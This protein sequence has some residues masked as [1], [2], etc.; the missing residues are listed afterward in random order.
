VSAVETLITHL[1]DDGIFL[2]VENDELRFRAP[3][4]RFSDTLKKDVSASK[5]EVIKWL[6]SNGHTARPDTS[7]P[8]RRTGRHEAPLTYAQQQLWLADRLSGAGATYNMPAHIVLKGKLKTERLHSAMNELVKRHE[9]LRTSF[10]SQFDE[11]RQIINPPSQL[12]YEI[13]DVEN[14]TS[15]DQYTR[16]E[17][18]MDRLAYSAFDLS[19]D[20]LLRYG[21]IRFNATHHNVILCLHHIVSD[22]WSMAVLLE[23]LIYFYNAYQDQDRPVLT[24][25]YADFAAWQKQSVNQAK[26]EEQIGFWKEALSGVPETSEFPTEFERPSERAF[27]GDEHA[28]DFGPEL[29]QAI[30]NLAKTEGTT[31]FSVLLAALYISLWRHSGQADLVIGTPVAGRVLQQTEPM[32]GLFATVLPLRAVVDG[33]DDFRTFLSTVT[34]VTQAAQANQAVP[35]ERI[36]ELSG[37]GRD[38]SRQPLFQ[39]AL[40]LENIPRP[41]MELDG[42]TVDLVRLESR[43]SRFDITIFAQDIADNIEGYVE[44]DPALYTKPRIESLLESIKAVLQKAVRQCD[45]PLSHLPVMTKPTL[46]QLISTSTGPDILRP[47]LCLHHYIE[48]QVLRTPDT[49]ALTFENRHLTYG[50][51]NEQ[52]NQLAIWLID[53]G[54]RPGDLVG[55]CLER[56]FDL[57]IALLAVMKSGRAYVP[58]DPTLPRDRLDFMVGDASPKVILCD[59]QCLQIFANMSTPAIDLQNLMIECQDSHAGNPSVSL[60][61]DDLIHVIYTSGSTGVP[62]G[63]TSCHAGALNRLLWG[64]EKYPLTDRDVLLQKTPYSFDVSVW[65][66]FWP[67]MQGARLV[68]AKPGGHKDP[69]YLAE[70]VDE[71]GITKIHFV[72]SMLDLFLD[73]KP[74]GSCTRLEHVICSGEALTPRLRQKFFQHFE[75]LLTNLYGPTEASIEVTYQDCYAEDEGAVPIGRPISNVDIFILDENRLPVPMGVVGELHIGGVALAQG[76][77]NRPDLTQDR[78]ITLPDGPLKGRRL[79]KTGD[80]ARYTSSGLIEYLGRT[81]HQIKLRGVRIELGE[82]ESHLDR[83]DKIAQSVVVA[84][85]DIPGNVYLASYILPVEPLTDQ[86]GFIESLKSSLSQSLPAYML[87]AAYVIMSE[88]PLTHNGKVDRKALPQPN[89]QT[90]VQQDKRLPVTQFEKSMA[91]LWSELLGIEV[92]GLEDDFFALGGNSLMVVRL[93]SRLKIDHD[94]DMSIVQFFKDPTIGAL[95]NFHQQGGLQKDNIVCLRNAKASNLAPPL[96]FIHPVGGHVM[97]YREVIDKLEYAGPIFGINHPDLSSQTSP[98]FRTVEALATLYVEHILQACDKGPI[99]LCGWSFGGLVSI[100]IA[101]QLR[102]LGRDVTFLGLIDTMAFPEDVRLV[103]SKISSSDNVFDHLDRVKNW[104]QKHSSVILAEN[105]DMGP[106]DEG[107]DTLSKH[108]EAIYYANLWAASRYEISGDIKNAYFY[109]AS[110]SLATYGYTESLENMISLSGETLNQI[111]FDADHYSIMVGDN[112]RRLADHLAL[113]IEASGNS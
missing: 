60:K 64:Q 76:Y 40:A 8:L 39:V 15:M 37:A 22:G 34:R 67:L 73:E 53:Q 54:V 3:K 50:E 87:P 9:S 36:I 101:N 42:L 65:E 47:D 25:Q 109:S 44:F 19:S 30:R 21:L 89:T 71:Q 98:I 7:L 13:L 104:T 6:V 10:V 26:I 24:A 48:E 16:V 5:T 52:A 56:S 82:I 46:E 83:N 14:L 41:K 70:I 106:I 51:M 45:A 28:F 59:N 100:E 102:V 97:G 63:V 33:T 75:C 112:A 103:G 72:P 99:Y 66:L 18:F 113:N 1:F 93:L 84:R 96:F 95:A 35:L 86:S 57:V 81:D 68:I 79:Y 4:G 77:L 110:K 29:S 80:L 90:H 31:V 38:F 88:F 74:K 105:V 78:F 32:I 94:M 23:E 107:D 20:P 58:L 11:P 55:L 69:N 108:V 92:I 85:E 27:V 111:S 12:E 43:N 2:W 49:P 62:K 61:G 91:D 17:N